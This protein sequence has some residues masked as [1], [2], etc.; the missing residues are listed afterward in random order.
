LVFRPLRTAF[1]EG[2]VRDRDCVRFLQWALPRLGLR[3]PG[4]RKVRG[5]VCKRVGRRLRALGLG[6][7]D[8]YRDVLAADPREWGHLEA[9]CRIPISRFWRDRGVFERLG[10]EVLPAL[11]ADALASGRRLV[12]CWSAG[13]ASGEETY[14]LRVVW[15]D[16]VQ[17]IFPEAEILI[18]GTDAEPTMI[19]RAEAACYGGGSLKDLPAGSRDRAFDRD[20]AIF[21]LRPELKE[22]VVFRLQDIREE[23]PEG[24]F[25]L[26]LCRNLVFTYFEEGLQAAVLGRLDDRLRAGG[27]LVI[28]SHERLPDDAPGYAPLEVT[29]PIYRKRAVGAR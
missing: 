25:D 8:A 2:A 28:G 11:A 9:F 23:Q 29:L 24:P 13:C 26:I 20:Y 3:W 22:G 19:A 7:L 16:R 4:Y 21:R 18:L 17:P 15:R 10:R 12:R 14:S 5:T 1:V 27:Y 6:D